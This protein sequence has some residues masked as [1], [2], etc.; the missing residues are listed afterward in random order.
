MKPAGRRATA[1]ETAVTLLV[2]GRRPTASAIRRSGA[3]SHAGSFRKTPS[4]PAAEPDSDYAAAAGEL[5]VPRR[6]GKSVR[7]KPERDHAGLVTCP[8]GRRSE[9][10]PPRSPSRRWPD[11]RAVA[12][13]AR[14]GGRA[15]RGPA[16]AARLPRWKRCREALHECD[17]AE[18]CIARVALDDAIEPPIEGCQ[19]DGAAVDG[20][21]VGC[22]TGSLFPRSAPAGWP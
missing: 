5:E 15:A 21:Q 22:L 13:A 2:R 12:G 10:I 4:G 14:P 20:P 9:K 3:G 19:A 11:K 1:A 7:R 6:A 8:A 17:R 18:A 16:P